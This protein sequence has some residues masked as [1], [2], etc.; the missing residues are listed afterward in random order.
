MITVTRSRCLFAFTWSTSKPFSVLWNVTCSN[1]AGEALGG[2][3]GDCHRSHA[4]Y[5][6]GR[7]CAEVTLKGDRH[8]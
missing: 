3:D 6:S 5:A 4:A 8:G 7:R 2:L 1:Q